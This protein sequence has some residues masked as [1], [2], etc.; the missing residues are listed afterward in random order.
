M[1]SCTAR[2]VCSPRCGAIGVQLAVRFRLY[3]TVRIFDSGHGD[4]HVHVDV[5]SDALVNWLTRDADGHAHV[6]GHAHDAVDNE[7][8]DVVRIAPT[9]RDAHGAGDSDF[10]GVTVRHH[11]SGGVTQQHTDGHA[12]ALHVADRQ[13]P[14][15]LVV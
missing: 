2:V 5:H 7:D 9:V 4:A 11:L 13:H 3:L 12:D 10:H 15:V 8:A 14:R 6:H 1:G